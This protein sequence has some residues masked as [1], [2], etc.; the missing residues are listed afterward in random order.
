MG[1]QISIEDLK[2][3]LKDIFCS[4]NRTYKRYSEVWLSDANFGGLY[5]SHKY[6][7]NVKADHEIPSCNSEIKSI[8]T[9]LFDKLKK[10]EWSLIWRVVVYNSFEEIHCASEDILVYSK[11]DACEANN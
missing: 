11:I 10:N 2:E 1:K 6:I 8:V 7:V 3:K 4:E 5:Q 9:K